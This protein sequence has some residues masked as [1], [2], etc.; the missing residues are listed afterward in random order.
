MK[1]SKLPFILLA[2]SLL[3][4]GAISPFA[5]AEAHDPVQSVEPVILVYAVG[6]PN[7]RNCIA[8]IL[9]NDSRVEE[10]VLLINST[11]AL[12]V[13]ILYPN[14]KAAI[15]VGQNPS[16]V[17][18]VQ[19]QVLSYFREGGGV[20]GF[21]EF[22]STENGILGSEVFPLYAN[23]SRLGKMNGGYFVQNLIR[24]DVTEINQDL[25]EM[26]T[27]RDAEIVLSLAKKTGRSANATPESGNYS[28]LY[29]DTAY[30]A[31][32]AVAYQ[33][34]GCSVSF[35]G[36][37]M[38]DSAGSKLKYFENLFSD[39]DFVELFLNSVDWVKSHET[40]THSLVQETVE[41]L[42]HAE[43][44]DEAIR[45]AAERFQQ[46]RHAANLVIKLCL[47]LGGIGIAAAAYFKLCKA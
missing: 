25:P 18:G 8:K 42:R 7:L 11:D 16:A 28:V 14:V 21:H 46:S 27:V 23:V 1:R 5:E 38:A 22:G 29:R 39:E 45:L 32:Y 17:L 40:R 20:V 37:D 4:A 31:P 19:D 13:A 47:N 9:E 34:G 15:L 10:K 30:G 44:A 6:M 3:L 41:S 36:G 12:S 43:Q 24:E 33:N 35:A 26:L 2:S